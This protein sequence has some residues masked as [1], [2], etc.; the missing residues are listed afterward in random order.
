MAHK[1]WITAGFVTVCYSM[2][3]VSRTSCSHFVC[4]GSYYATHTLG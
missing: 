4:Q 1:P 3:M 2:S